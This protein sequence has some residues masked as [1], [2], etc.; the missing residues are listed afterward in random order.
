MR[1]SGQAP[2]RS[3]K[4]YSAGELSVDADRH[5]VRFAGAVLRLKPREF[6]LLLLFVRNEGRVFTRDQL[7]ESIWGFDYEGDPRTVDVHIRR[8][9]RA[10]GE[11]AS[12]PGYLQ[13]V[14]G[15]GYKF[16]APD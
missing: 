4:R 1:R 7:I 13:T 11:R 8:L 2:P 3:G 16:S 15:V 10:L 5:E 6:D 9:R 12:A 14:H